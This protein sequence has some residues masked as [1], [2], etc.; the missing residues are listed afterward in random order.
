MSPDKA[1]DA[2]DAGDLLNGKGRGSPQL[3]E[4]SS[5]DLRNRK[6]DAKRPAVRSGVHVPPFPVAF[7]I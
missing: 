6:R 4:S 7:T 3:L 5:G 2:V 1:V